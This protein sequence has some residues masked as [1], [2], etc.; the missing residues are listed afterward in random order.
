[1]PRQNFRDIL[2]SK[3]K[4]QC[5]GK[6]LLCP[7][8]I[9]LSVLHKYSLRNVRSACTP[10]TPASVPLLLLPSILRCPPVHTLLQIA[11]IAL[12]LPPIQSALAPQ[13]MCRR[14]PTRPLARSPAAVATRTLSPPPHGPLTPRRFGGGDSGMQLPPPRSSLLALG[15]SCS[16]S[17]GVL[18]SLSRESESDGIL[19]LSPKI[20]ALPLRLQSQTCAPRSMRGSVANEVPALPFL[21]PPR[22]FLRFLFPV[23]PRL[24]PPLPLSPHRTQ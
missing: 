7:L 21:F 14:L 23:I 20:W 5:L 15:T 13:K 6:N 24:L 4:G 18:W 9:I 17:V 16:R 11:A 8:L 1:M 12:S 10:Y 2:L 19:V 3:F 22:A